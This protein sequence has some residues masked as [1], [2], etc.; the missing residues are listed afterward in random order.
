MLNIVN[1]SSDKPNYT[2]EEISTAQCY[3]YLLL[4]MKR[5][6]DIID[7]VDNNK[8]STNRFVVE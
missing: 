4:G 7:D 3:A 5:L 8:L 1:K 6:V 2:E